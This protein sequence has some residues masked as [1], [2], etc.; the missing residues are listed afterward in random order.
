[1]KCEK[2]AT[3]KCRQESNKRN[4][5]NSVDWL[6]WNHFVPKRGPVAHSFE[7]GNVVLGL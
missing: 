3:T 7:Y 6:D 1:V 2:L 5:K 4:L